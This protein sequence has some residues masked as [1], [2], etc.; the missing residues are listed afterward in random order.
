MKEEYEEEKRRLEQQQLIRMED[1][2]RREEQAHTS[3]LQTLLP[4]HPFMLRCNSDMHLVSAGGN[5][6]VAGAN[7]DAASHEQ[8]TEPAL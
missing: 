1:A 7:A 4:S 2:E 3:R 5:E 8:R 6:T